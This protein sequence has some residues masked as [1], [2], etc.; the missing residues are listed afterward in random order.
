MKGVDGL[1]P[2]QRAQLPKESRPADEAY[3]ARLRK[4]FEAHGPGQKP[5]DFDRFVQA[6]LVWDEAM[7]ENAAAYLTANP[8]KRMVVLAGAGHIAFGSGIPSRLERRTHASYA[9][10]INNNG[11]EDIGPHF[12]DYILLSAEQELPPAGTLGVVLESK[13]GESLIKSLVPE[14]AAEK[15]GLKRGDA[16]VEID[17][18]PVKKTSD[19]KLALWNRKPGDEV[20]V[21]VHAKRRFGGDGNQEIAV[22]LAAPPKNPSH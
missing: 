3:R 8:D 5:E 2:E 10:V 19:V 14:G 17:G 11:G 21:K 22:T 6:Q 16:I 4:A 13:D 20:H 12:A 1:T 15:A 18:Q 9:T 7:A